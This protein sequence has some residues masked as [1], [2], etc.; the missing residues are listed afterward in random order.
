VYFFT[1]QCSSKVYIVYTSST[2]YFISI[3]CIYI[4]YTV[5]LHSTLYI[6][7]I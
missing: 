3:H 6:D 5:R 4:L 7:I 2:V 1:V